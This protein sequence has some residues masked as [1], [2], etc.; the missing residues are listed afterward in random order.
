MC[1]TRNVSMSFDSKKISVTA[2][3][4]L[5]LSTQKARLISDQGTEY[6]VDLYEATT[7]ITSENQHMSANV[8]TQYVT[9]YF[10]VIDTGT[11]TPLASGSQN[12]T[13]WDPSGAIYGTVSIYYDKIGTTY[14][15]TRCTGSWTIYDSTCTLSERIVAVSCYH[16]TTSQWLSQP[17][18]SNSFDV[19][20]G[21]TN[22]ANSTQGLCGIGGNSVCIITRGGHSWMFVVECMI[23]GSMPSL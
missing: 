3:Q 15:T 22:Y 9:T 14:K 23:A 10:A 18:S 8:S 21:F 6:L 20:T 1:V 4:P 2:A 17:V 11:I 13:L 16:G 12:N 19:T 5:S 7:Q